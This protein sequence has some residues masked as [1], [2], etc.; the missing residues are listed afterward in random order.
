MINILVEI[1]GTRLHDKIPGTILHVKTQ[2]NIVHD[3]IP[4]HDNVC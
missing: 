1:P 4:E 2:G 3:N